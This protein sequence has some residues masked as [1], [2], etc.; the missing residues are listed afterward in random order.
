MTV[1]IPYLWGVP[2]EHE[3]LASGIVNGGGIIDRVW[4][5]WCIY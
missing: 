2:A 1:C 4:R 5:E 3:R